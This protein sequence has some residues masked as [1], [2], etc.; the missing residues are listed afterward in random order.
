MISLKLSFFAFLQEEFSKELIITIKEPI[1]LI[2]LFDLFSSKTGENGRKFF[3]NNGILKTDFI[4]LI[5][6]RNI[7]ALNGLS[8]IL[9]IN[10]E[11][12]FFPLLGGGNFRR[13]FNFYEIYVFFLMPR[14]L[15]YMSSLK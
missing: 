9:D 15:D 12:S 1:R 8:T 4:I 13:K 6:G 3:L 7:Q 11:I 14:K 2:Q 10:S 5:N